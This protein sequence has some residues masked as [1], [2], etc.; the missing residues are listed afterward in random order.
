MKVEGRCADYSDLVCL[1]C[2]ARCMFLSVVLPQLVR[3]SE[4]GES[5]MIIDSSS[6]FPFPTTS[7]C[8]LSSPPY[9]TYLLSFQRVPRSLA[10]LSE[11]LLESI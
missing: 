8:L 1:S 10:N 2:I 5:K 6:L 7:K 3:K 4:V 9:L 11:F